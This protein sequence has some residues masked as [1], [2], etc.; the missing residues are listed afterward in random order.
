MS[1]D[2]ALQFHIDGLTDVPN[3]TN[4]MVLEYFANNPTYVVAK[5]AQPVTVQLTAQQL[6]TLLGTNNVWSDADSVTVDYVA[7]TKLY[8]EQ[9]TE[10]DADMV[11]DAN[12]TSGAYFMVGNA[13]F[14][15]TANI[16]SGAAIVPGVN[17]TR[18]NLA[19]ALNALNA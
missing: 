9:L 10:P 14:L 15:A 17:C 12:I 7:D 3:F 18:T 19:E 8:I 11:A 2:S 16:A 4:A 13:L 1:Q 6:T 5:L